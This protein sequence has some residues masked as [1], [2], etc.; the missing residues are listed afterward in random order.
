[1]RR[2]IEQFRFA[3]MALEMQIRTARNEFTEG[4]TMEDFTE[5]PRLL[6]TGEIRALSPADLSLLI[7]ETDNPDLLYLLSLRRQ[8]MNR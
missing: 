4:T 6:T 1:M 7:R 2:I 8:E 3:Y 5:K